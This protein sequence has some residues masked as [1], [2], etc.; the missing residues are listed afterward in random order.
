[1]RP[2][3]YSSYLSCYD[4]YTNQSSNTSSR[5]NAFCSL[6]GHLL[7]YLH[8]LTS[9]RNRTPHFGMPLILYLHPNVAIY[10]DMTALLIYISY[11]FLRPSMPSILSPN[12]R[13]ALPSRATYFCRINSRFPVYN[14]LHFVSHK[15]STARRNRMCTRARL[16]SKL[17]SCGSIFGPIERTLVLTR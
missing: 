12:D 17:F 11:I 16:V 4:R 14:P 7:R 3:G 2:Q 6:I 9:L 15:T 5:C 8:S 1:V 13:H 10:I